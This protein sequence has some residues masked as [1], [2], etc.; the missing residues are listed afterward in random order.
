MMNAPAPMIGGISWPPVEAAASTPPANLGL[1]PIRFIMGMVMEPVPTVLATAL[2]ETDPMMPEAKTAILAG[3]PV[4]RPISDR[5]R[6]MMNS[7]APDLIRNA[8]NKTNR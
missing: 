3:P 8:A 2:P 5:A 4:V 1:N 7:P 6:L